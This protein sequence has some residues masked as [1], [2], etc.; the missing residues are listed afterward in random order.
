MTVPNRLYCNEQQMLTTTRPLPA[1]HALA[2]QVSVDIYITSWTLLSC[3]RSMCWKAIRV[4]LFD[5]LGLA[6]NVTE[7]TFKQCGTATASSIIPSKQALLSQ[8]PKAARHPKAN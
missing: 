1:G 4:Q 2:F 3:L 6:V 8:A 7:A 5:N